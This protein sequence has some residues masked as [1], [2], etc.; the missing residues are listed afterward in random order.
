MISTFL[1]DAE[2]KDRE[3]ELS[4]DAPREL[5]EHHILWVDACDP[6]AAELARPN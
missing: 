2:G 3:I 1:Y 6:D 5:A 4:A